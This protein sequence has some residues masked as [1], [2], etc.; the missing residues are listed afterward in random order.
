ME[1]KPGINSLLEQRFIMCILCFL[2]AGT[3]TTKSRTETMDSGQALC[4]VFQDVLNSREPGR[5]IYIYIQALVAQ[6]VKGLLP[7]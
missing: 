6:C 2:P 3:K 5:N 7:R 4:G 1:T